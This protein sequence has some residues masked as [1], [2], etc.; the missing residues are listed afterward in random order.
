MTTLKQHH[1]LTQLVT[2]AV[3]TGILLLNSACGTRGSYSNSFYSRQT[4]GD[5]QQ[6]F[7]PAAGLPTATA[8]EVQQIAQ[9]TPNP[10]TS[11]A[12]LTQISE[13]F[14]ELN[15]CY[16]NVLNRGLQL[17][18]EGRQ[19][20]QYIF[21]GSGQELVKCYQYIVS[22]KNRQYQQDLQRRQAQEAWNNYILQLWQ[23]QG[24]SS[25]SFAGYYP[26]MQIPRP[27]SVGGPR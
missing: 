2:L 17:F 8:Q 25:G 15:N 20:T 3:I 21:T 19:N 13:D 5:N 22:E 6:F 14:G 23:R 16:R 9:S 24:G 1:R 12:Q 27:P 10:S 26:D 11:A 4:G 18:Q 7:A